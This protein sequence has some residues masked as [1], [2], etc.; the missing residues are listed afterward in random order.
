MV[1]RAS[2]RHCCCFF[3]RMICYNLRAVVGS[4]WLVDRPGWWEVWLVMVDGLMGG[5]WWLAG[6]TLFK[7]SLLGDWFLVAGS[8]WLSVGLF[9]SL[10][11]RSSFLVPT[12]FPGAPRLLS[13]LS[14]LLFALLSRSRIF[15]GLLF[16]FSFFCPWY[17]SFFLLCL[18]NG[19]PLLRASCCRRSCCGRSP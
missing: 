18:P 9:S 8:R 6:G 12:F 4:A 14:C 17:F 5:G 13:C 11:L 19:L 3:G 16:H 2:W 15:G 10:W 1:G 7:H